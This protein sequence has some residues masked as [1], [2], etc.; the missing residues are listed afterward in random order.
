MLRAVVFVSGMTSL[1]AEM[2]ASRLLEP[3]FGTSIF[4]WANIIGLILIYLSVGYFLGG[5]IA[6]RHPNETYL[7]RLTAIAAIVIMVIP[8]V[9]RPILQLSLTAF[10]TVSVGSFLGSLLGTILL[11]AIPITL[12]GCV[13]PFAI[14]LAVTKIEGAGNVAGSLYALSTVGSIVGTFLPVLVFIPTIGTARTLI[15]FG[16][17]LLVLSAIGLRSMAMA[18]M[19]AIGVLLFVIPPGVIKPAVGMIAERESDYNYIQVIDIQGITELLLNEGVSIHS[20]FIKSDDNS[21]NPV[22]HLTRAYWDYVLIAPYFNPQHTAQTVRRAA[23]IGMGA[24]TMA[25]ELTYFYGPVPIDGVEID[26]AIIDIGRQYFELNEPNVHTYAQDGRY[27][28]RTTDT[29]YDLISVDA[30]HTPYIPFQLTTQEFFQEIGEHLTPDG[31]VVINVGRTAD[32]VA[33]VDDIARTMRLDFPSVYIIN[34]PAPPGTLILNS[35]IV[36]SPVP[37][38]R[39]G[40]Q[41]RV[42]GLN[43]GVLRQLGASAMQSLT[44]VQPSQGLVFTDDHAP[45]EQVVDSMIVHYLRTE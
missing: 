19:V 39:D 5:R 31:T 22:D 25:K 32:D 34:V 41:T 37:W 15:L 20:I 8:F 36:A 18:V 38:N 17:A 6:D 40:I 14:R 24:G 16:L 2:C 1:A 11:F 23:I 21:P 9:S 44:L 13:S 33:L 42:D 27:F 26:P 12:L 29:K 43:N 28:L 4:V 30:Y 10:A 35:L 45:V 3:Y 7:Y